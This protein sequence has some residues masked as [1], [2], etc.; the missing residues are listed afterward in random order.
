MHVGF[1]PIF[2]ATATYIE[3]GLYYPS[4]SSTTTQG[5]KSLRTI[6][7][8]MIWFLVMRGGCSIILHIRA[9]ASSWNRN[10]SDGFLAQDGFT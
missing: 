6:K 3:T 4:A 5:I 1:D 10:G 9:K 8:R 2:A 7:D